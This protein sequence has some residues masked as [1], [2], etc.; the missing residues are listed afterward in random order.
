MMQAH[1]PS[2]GQDTV[3]TR[4]IDLGLSPIPPGSRPS[5]TQG[6]YSHEPDRCPSS[7]GFLPGLFD[8][9]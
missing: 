7:P 5:S 6:G 2:R 8:H 3:Y 9:T 1:K 4:E